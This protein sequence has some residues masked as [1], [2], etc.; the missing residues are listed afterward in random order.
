MIKGV[1]KS[2]YFDT[3]AWVVTEAGC[4]LECTMKKRAM[5]GRVHPVHIFC[6]KITGLSGVEAYEELHNYAPRSVD[7]S[8]YY[9]FRA[10]LHNAVRS[11]N[12]QCKQIGIK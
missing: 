8:Q 6:V 12:L 5:A 10:A 3:L 2:M 11:Y 9:G 4:K 1:K 7:D